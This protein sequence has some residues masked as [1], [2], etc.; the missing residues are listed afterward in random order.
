MGHEIIVRQK[1]KLFKKVLITVIWEGR[2]IIWK[3]KSDK[4]GIRTQESN[5]SSAPVKESFRLKLPP[6]TTRASCLSAKS[7]YCMEFTLSESL[8]NSGS[9]HRSGF[10]I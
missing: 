7:G 10:N 4:T 9:Y 3:K 8:C 1:K 2:I 5:D 6:S